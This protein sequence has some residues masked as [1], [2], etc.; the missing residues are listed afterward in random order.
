MSAFEDLVTEI[1]RQ[2]SAG[3]EEEILLAVMTGPNSLDIGDMELTS[4][5]LMFNEHL[6]RPVATKVSGS[7]SGNEFIDKTTYLS[8]L[9]AG[10]TVAVKRYSDSLYLVLGK[11]VRI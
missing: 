2:S 10:D 11:M 6:G 4:E 1:R 3:K 7:V 5:D 8:S 9:K